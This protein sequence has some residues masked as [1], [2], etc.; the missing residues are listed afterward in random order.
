MKRLINYIKNKKRKILYMIIEYK[1]GSHDY[2]RG[3][4]HILKIKKENLPIT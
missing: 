3:K 4:E 2:F 1:D